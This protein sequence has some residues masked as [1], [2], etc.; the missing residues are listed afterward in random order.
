MANIGELS[1]GVKVDQ[2]SINSAT[3]KIKDDFKQT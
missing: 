1:V 2:G 3:K